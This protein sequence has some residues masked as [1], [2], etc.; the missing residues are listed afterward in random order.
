MYY[1]EDTARFL[2]IMVINFE[3]FTAKS[4]K[5]AVAEQH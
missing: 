4:F 2:G 5:Q 3:W 1:V